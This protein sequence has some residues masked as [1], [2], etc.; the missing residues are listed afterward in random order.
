MP[1]FLSLQCDPDKAFAVQIQHEENVLQNPTSFM[2]CAL[3]FT[4]SAGERRIR[5]VLALATLETQPVCY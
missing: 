3:L 5:Q 2:Q 4:S 1:F